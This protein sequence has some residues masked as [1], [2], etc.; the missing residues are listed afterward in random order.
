MGAAR[1]ARR[2]AR[3]RRS[4][5]PYEPGRAA[6]AS[7]RRTQED[8]AALAGGR[9]EELPAALAEY[10]A[11]GA[12]APRA[13]PLRRRAAEA[14]HSTAPSASSRAPERA[15]RSSS[16]AEEIRELLRAG[17]AARARSRS[18]CPSVER[19][20]A[21]LETVLGTLGDPVRDRGPRPPRRRRRSA[22]RCSRCSASSG[23]AA[24]A[25]ISTPS[26]ARPTPASRARTSTSSRAACAAVASPRGRRSRRRRSASATAAAARRSRRCAAREARSRACARSPPRCCAAPTASKRRPSARQP[27]R[28]ARATRRSRAARRARGLARARRRARAATR[29]SRALER[30]EVRLGAAGERGRVA[31]ARP[32]RARTRRFE[33]VFL[34]GLEE[35]TLP[36]RATRSPFLDDDAR[37]ELDRRSA[38]GSTRPDPVERERYLFYTACTRAARRLYLV[39]E[40]ATDEGSPREP[41]PFWEEVAALFDAEERPP[42]DAP[43]AA[44]AADVAAR[45][46]AD[47]AGAAARARPAVRP[48]R[49]TAREALARANG[50]ERRLDRARARVHARDAAPA[51]ARARGARARRR[52]S[53]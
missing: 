50:W 15:A 37:G 52:R 24:A 5:C 40:A 35:G 13:P 14:R 47:R 8:L 19:W 11:P 30:A 48:R 21:P 46:G 39:R 6:F 27:R 38:R 7:L 53:T 28:P 22:R 45:G 10:G 12:R 2:R 4:R 36:R 44:L 17:I 16:S 29:S 23:T 20:R 18:S 41:S 9:I 1:G 42:L 49:P 51:S 3:G 43:A 31:V 26:S 25:A 32:A 34:L 33:A